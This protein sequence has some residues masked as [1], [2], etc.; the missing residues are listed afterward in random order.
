MSGNAALLVAL[1]AAVIGP[2]VAYFTASRKLSGKIGTSE[3]AQLWAES[4]NIRDDYRQRLAVSDSR[5]VALEVRVATLEG[6]N[7]ELA[8]ENLT[9]TAKI[10]GY[11]ETIKELRARLDVLEKENLAL[12]KQ[13]TALQKTLSKE[14][15]Q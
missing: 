3:A 1:G 12:R 2:L 9:L 5:Q 15:K 8:R 11:E 7:T 4:T 10:V 13:V 14:R 6:L